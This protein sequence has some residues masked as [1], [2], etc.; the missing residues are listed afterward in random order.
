[1]YRVRVGGS[2]ERQPFG[3]SQ[4]LRDALPTAKADRLCL[5]R[6]FTQ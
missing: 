2:Q 3:F 5:G 6:V 4:D 1:M